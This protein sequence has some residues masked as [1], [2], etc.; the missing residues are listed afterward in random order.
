MSQTYVRY[1]DKKNYGWQIVLCIFRAVSKLGSKHHLKGIKVDFGIHQ[2]IKGIHGITILFVFLYYIENNVINIIRFL[3]HFLL[4]WVFW[5]KH[6]ETL[7]KKG[8]CMSDVIIRQKKKCSTSNRSKL[9][10]TLN[11]IAHFELIVI[12][13]YWTSAKDRIWSH[14]T[15]I[16]LYLSSVLCVPFLTK[17]VLKLVKKFWPFPKMSQVW[18]GR[19]VAMTLFIVLLVVINTL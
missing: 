7:S 17:E 2:R 6:I 8:F 14:S 10:P 11:F 3:L 1:I 12:I 18:L 19:S 4:Y 15:T 13:K 5:E 9:S 16:F